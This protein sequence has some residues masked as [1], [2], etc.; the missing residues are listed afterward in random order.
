MS[1]KTWSQKSRFGYIHS[2]QSG[3]HWRNKVSGVIK[4][5][6]LPFEEVSVREEGWLSIDEVRYLLNRLH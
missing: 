1:K 3:W 6:D 2:K 5:K 4:W